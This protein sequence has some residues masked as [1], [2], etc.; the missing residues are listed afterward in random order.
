MMRLQRSALIFA[1]ATGI[2]VVSG[3]VAAQTQEPPPVDTA[4]PAPRKPSGGIEE[5]TITGTRVKGRTALETAAP[6]D[7]INAA[8]FQKLGDTDISNMVR[9]AVPS[10]NVNPQ[11]I[12]DA[13][14]IV[15][16]AN[17]RGL[18]PDSTLILVNGKRRHRSAVIS[19]L[20]GGLSDGAQG[21][22]VSTIPSMA[23]QRVEVLRDGAAAQYGSDAIAGVINFVLDDA[24]EGLSLETK[25]GQ[26]Y[27]RDGDTFMVGGN[28]GVPLPMTENGFAN[29]TFEWRKADETSRTVQRDDAQ[30]L[31][32]AGNTFVKDPAQT[33]GTPEVDDDL[34]FF[35]N[36]A[37]PIAD[38]LE[39][40]T[41]G[42]YAERDVEGGFFFRNPDTREGV[43]QPAGVSGTR[44]VADLD[45]L[46]VGGSCPTT[47]TNDPG[48]LAQVEAD[49]NCFAFNEMF[50]GGFTPRFG[51][52]VEDHSAVAGVRGE[53]V[54]GFSY[55]VSYGI[56]RDRV[57]YFIFNTINASLG[58]DSPT[59]FEPGSYIQY[60][61][62]L[63]VDF[64]YPLKVA[65]FASDLNIA[66][67]FEYR[68]E[69]FEAEIGDDASFQ[70][71]PLVGQGF[72]VGSNGFPGFGPQVADDFSRD[73]I[74]GYLDLEAN[75][76][77]TVLIGAAG[78]V[79]RFNDFGSTTN[80]K[81][82][83]RWDPVDFLGFRATIATGFRAPTPGQSNINNVSTVFEN[84][85]LINRGTIPATNPIAS[86]KGGKQL[87]PEESV[88]Y[89]FGIV[90]QFA[91]FTTTLD[92]FQID[93]KDRITQS[94]SFVLTPQE[95]A[96]LVAAGVTGAQSLDAF[97]FFVNDFD[98]QT[99]G[100]DLVTSYPFEVLGGPTNLNLVFNWTQTKVQSFN[101]DLLDPVRIRQLEE[102]L[103]EFRGSLSATHEQG[104]F[105][106][107]LR[108]NYF[109][110]Y[111]EAHLDDGTLPIK[112]GA[113]FT[114]DAELTYRFL[115]RFSFS[116]GADNIFDAF[117][118]KNEFSGVAGSKYPATAPMGFNGGF[119]YVRLRYDY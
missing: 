88:S 45:G 10:Y 25:W 42:G 105:T 99:Q 107:A 93:V 60:E 22:D 87:D 24:S 114:V 18:P 17:L 111:F 58:P 112:P 36:S 115:E 77:D 76:T 55:D 103:P 69:K 104:P 4:K 70:V 59:S 29:M 13:A 30:A 50:P 101:A 33:F 53:F 71:G 21:P 75:I 98:T 51:G 110:K 102:S 15:R 40:Y 44:L 8:E 37:V 68:E 66:S 96:T 116:V 56:G 81:L 79:E 108:L 83:G 26:Q 23:L 38:E 63:N 14:T 41:F 27:E 5:L 65:A 31:I 90:G 106:G 48:A 113:E 67:G 97:R 82:S 57:D 119:Y 43:F 84:G 80:G 61:R 28:L 16:P 7:L 3:P 78:R 1:I 62:N 20:G 95:R 89:S 39:L 34:K 94:Q 35:L 6:V 117:P 12:S 109:G 2:T 9:A 11:P 118:D 86:L 32:D 73:N 74:A 19:F 91:D 72:S 85:M 100:V 92:Y 47:L 46:G 52:E 49:P 64:N 54:S